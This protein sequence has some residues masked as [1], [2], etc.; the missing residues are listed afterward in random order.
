MRNLGKITLFS[1]IFL[2]AGCVD[3]KTEPPSPDEK[4]WHVH[5]I[6]PEGSPVTGEYVSDGLWFRDAGYMGWEHP[7]TG[8]EYWVPRGYDCYGIMKNLTRREWGEIEPGAS[9]LK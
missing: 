8:V 5:V 4:V 9:G 2:L 1:S 3:G 6:C 7:Y